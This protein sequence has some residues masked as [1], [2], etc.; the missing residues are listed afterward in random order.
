MKEA[1][2]EDRSAYLIKEKAQKASSSVAENR[3]STDWSPA[4]AG[5]NDYLIA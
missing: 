2:A 3:F 1:I 4:A 5:S